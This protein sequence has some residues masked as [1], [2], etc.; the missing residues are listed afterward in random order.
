MKN[1]N[2]LIQSLR[3]EFTV[4]KLFRFDANSIQSVED[5]VHRLIALAEKL[6]TAAKD[7]AAAQDL[8]FNLKAAYD[9]LLLPALR[10]DELCDNLDL[11]IDEHLP[12][13]ARAELQATYA[14][15][16]GRRDKFLGTL[17]DVLEKIEAAAKKAFPP[18][19]KKPREA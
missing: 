11:E 5:H 12:P 18:R 6:N 9:D 1:Q 13:P 3:D 19:R 2:L 14:A 10:D 7:N 8:L 16:T 17:E 4:G 15:A